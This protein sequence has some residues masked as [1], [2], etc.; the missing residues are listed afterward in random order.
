MWSD[1]DR[2]LAEICVSDH[3]WG[4]VGGWGEEVFA[5]HTSASQPKRSTPARTPF[6]LLKQRRLFT[7]TMSGLLRSLRPLTAPPG[8]EKQAAIVASST[9]SADHSHHKHLSSWVSR[10]MLVEQLRDAKK[11]LASK[12]KRKMPS[13]F[14]RQSQATNKENDWNLVV[15]PGAPSKEE[16]KMHSA[17]QP[18]HSVTTSNVDPAQSEEYPPYVEP[19]VKMPTAYQVQDRCGGTVVG[20]QAVIFTNLA[21]KRK[22]RRFSLL[23]AI[24][25]HKQAVTLDR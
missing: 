7:I 21:F 15:L 11:N 19:P 12:T 6:T 8:D 25:E 5:V 14:R 23:H 2:S 17:M 3:P 24:P 4:W 10:F 9:S 16:K 1:Y 20:G 13:L 22:L 18:V